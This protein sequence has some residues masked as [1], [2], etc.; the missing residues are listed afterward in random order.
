MSNTTKEINRIT[1]AV[2][3]V[4]VKLMVLA[5]VILLLYEAVI[6]GFAFGHQIFYA[7]AVEEVP[8]TEM[9]VVID[10]GTSASEAAGQLEKRGLIKNQFA[11]LFQSYFYDYKTIYPGTYQL[12]TSMTSKEILQLLNEKP[13]EEVKAAVAGAAGTGSSGAGSS[14]AAGRSADSENAAKGQDGIK[15]AEASGQGTG[16]AAGASGQPAGDAVGAAAQ[17]AGAAAG[18]ETYSGNPAYYGEEEDQAEGGW[19]EDATE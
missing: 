3:A 6:W 17:P 2:I 15:A 5:L 9:T 1:T 14:A 4:S 10:E 16:N 19:I 18:A 13:E 11:F 8:G 12:N 7:E